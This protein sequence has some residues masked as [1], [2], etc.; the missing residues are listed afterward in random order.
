MSPSLIRQL[1]L[2]ILFGTLVCWDQPKRLGFLELR[3]QV[4]SLVSVLLGAWAL[5]DFKIPCFIGQLNHISSQVWWLILI[6]FWF[7]FIE[8]IPCIVI[9]R[10]CHLGFTIVHR[11]HFIWYLS[12]R[13]LKFRSFTKFLKNW[14]SLCQGVGVFCAKDFTGSFYFTGLFIECLTLG[15]Q[16]NTIANVF[17]V[18]KSNQFWLP[19]T[20]GLVKYIILTTLWPLQIFPEHYLLLFLF[21]ISGECRG[22][23]YRLMNELWWDLNGFNAFSSCAVVFGLFKILR[24]LSHRLI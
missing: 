8:I 7:H 21:A 19:M 14:H 15:P 1:V 23:S 18:T 2:W 17:A 20:V 4:R 3:W 12:T 10:R 24:C 9:R 5:R 11:I 16:Q 13:L 22:R 6:Q